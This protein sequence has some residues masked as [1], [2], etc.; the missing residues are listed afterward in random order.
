MIEQSARRY[1]KLEPYARKQKL[2]ALLSRRG[3]DGE[4]INAALR[5]IPGE[6]TEE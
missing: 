4:T 5:E 6:S 1:A 3:F 2:W